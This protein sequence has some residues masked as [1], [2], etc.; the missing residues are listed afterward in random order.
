M[1][2]RQTGKMPL[3]RGGIDDNR[4]E[5]VAAQA[6]Q[7]VAA[8]MIKAASQDNFL[9][10]GNQFGVESVAGD[11]DGFEPVPAQ[12]PQPPRATRHSEPTYDEL[13]AELDG[14]AP[15][16]GAPV[17]SPY[18]KQAAPVAYA[19]T[20]EQAYMAQRQRVSL[21]LSDSTVNL[22]CIDCIHSRYGV[23]LLLPLS[24]DGV[25]FMPKEG[26]ELTLR[27]GDSAIPCY[28]PGTYFE[29]PDLKLCGMAL[30]K[31]DA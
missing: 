27:I 29:V 17:P 13:S 10:E 16:A 12:T 14:S 31:R 24:Q 11:M 23:T 18:I 4:P 20:K 2:K 28:F 25:T 7:N 22:S 19:Q 26:T 9:E 1:N 6:Q 30:I 8:A 21:E 5:V 15:K 3:I